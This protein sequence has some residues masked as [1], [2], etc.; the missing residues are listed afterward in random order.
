MPTHTHSADDRSKAVEQFR[1]FI[2]QQ[3]R[4]LNADNLR[5][6]SNSIT[7]NIFNLINSAQDAD[8]IAGILAIGMTM[9]CTSACERERER[10]RD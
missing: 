1:T 8:K 2:T 4:E 5:K 10:E 9:C 3:Q 6:F 7:E